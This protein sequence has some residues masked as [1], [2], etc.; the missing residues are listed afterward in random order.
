[1]KPSV[2]TFGY[3]YY[4]YVTCR[5]DDGTPVINYPE[6]V[7]KAIYFTHDIQGIKLPCEKDVFYLLD[8]AGIYY[9]EDSEGEVTGE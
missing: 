9:V 2:K 5:L 6:N 3:K 7:T 1:M 8:T 4:S